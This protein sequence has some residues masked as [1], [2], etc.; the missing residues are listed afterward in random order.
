M[1]TPLCF[2]LYNFHQIILLRWAV[3]YHP[4]ASSR[5]IDESVT[6]SYVLPKIP[7][8]WPPQIVSAAN[9]LKLETASWECY[10]FVFRMEVGW[11][12][13]HL[14]RRFS[15]TLYYIHILVKCPHVSLRARFH[16]FC[17]NCSRLLVARVSS[18]IHRQV[19]RS[20]VLRHGRN[21]ILTQN[22]ISGGSGMVEL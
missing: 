11:S 6:L 3:W 16:W 21:Q 7:N 5:S 8:G 2:C 19:D 13:V 15:A 1:Q 18:M 14:S 9:I 20:G 12:N 4:K 17:S 10:I 22:R